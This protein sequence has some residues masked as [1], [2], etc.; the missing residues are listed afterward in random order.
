MGLCIVLIDMA[1]Y[2]LNITTLPNA[3]FA[4]IK[5]YLSKLPIIH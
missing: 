3:V 1:Q 5:C 2:I 4:S